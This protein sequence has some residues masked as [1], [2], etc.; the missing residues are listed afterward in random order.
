MKTDRI[1]SVLLLQLAIFF[2]SL[3]SVISKLASIQL[4][5]H[6]LFSFQCIGM[7]SIMVL[8]LGLYAVVWQISL[9][10]MKLSVAYANKGITLLWSLLW[11]VIL[12]NDSVTVNNIIGIALVLCGIMVVNVYE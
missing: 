1:R 12:F 11:S 5:A 2:Y 3:V 7:L 4:N 10:K 6:G 9:K 8:M